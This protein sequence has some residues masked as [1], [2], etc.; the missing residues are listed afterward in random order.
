LV[1]AA[2]KTVTWEVTRLSL[3]TPRE[4]RQRPTLT[5]SDVRLVDRRGRSQTE[6]SEAHGEEGRLGNEHFGVVKWMW[7]NIGSRE[8][9]CW[10]VAGC[11]RTWSLLRLMRDV[12]WYLDVGSSTFLYF[13]SSSLASELNMFSVLGEARHIRRV[14]LAEGTEL[15]SDS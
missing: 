15:A 7:A 5:G 11:L 14:L 4:A 13:S 2:F 3:R 6:E 8:L 1:R 12:W 10:C 9:S